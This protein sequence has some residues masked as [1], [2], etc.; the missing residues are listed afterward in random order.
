MSDVNWHCIEN[1][2][3]LMIEYKA[4]ELMLVTGQ[5]PRF[6]INGEFQSL[7]QPELPFEKS[8]GSMGE[9]PSAMLADYMDD[10]HRQCFYYTNKVNFILKKHKLSDSGYDRFIV[11]GLIQQYG[12]SF[13]IT[14]I[15]DDTQYQLAYK[16]FEET[17]PIKQISSYISGLVI[18]TG[19][20]LNKVEKSQLLSSVIDYRNRHYQHHILIIEDQIIKIHQNKKSLIQQVEVL[21]KSSCR[22]SCDA[23]NEIFAKIDAI[24]PDMLVIDSIDSLTPSSLKKILMLSG[25]GCLV[26]ST[27]STTSLVNSLYRIEYFFTK[28]ERAYIRSILAKNLRHII[29]M[30]VSETQSHGKQYKWEVMNNND[31]AFRLIKKGNYDS[32]LIENK[33]HSM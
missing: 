11:S 19:S 15:P 22:P 5:T 13:I 23:D 10:K 25:S 30:E 31:E 16:K 1:L 3:T 26:I 17:L 7:S 12:G 21:N 27:M 28:N 9:L 20:L 18:F 6:R 32:I 33:V 2:L 29:S 4:T 24:A 14:Y 8:G